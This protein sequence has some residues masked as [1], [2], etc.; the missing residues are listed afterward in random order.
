LLVSC[1]TYFWRYV[2]L[3]R[4]LTLSGL[5]GVISQKMILF[6]YRL[7]SVITWKITFWMLQICFHCLKVCFVLSSNMIQPVVRSCYYKQG[8]PVTCSHLQIYSCLEKQLALCIHCI[9]PIVI[10]SWRRGGVLIWHLAMFHPSSVMVW[11]TSFSS[12]IGVVLYTVR[13]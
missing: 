6:T 13:P 1:W 7:H 2:P 11:I 9:M 12:S 10:Y 4:R 3:K 5:H 8:L